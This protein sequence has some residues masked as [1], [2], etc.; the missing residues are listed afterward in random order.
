MFAVVAGV[1]ISSDEDCWAFPLE[2][3]VGFGASGVAEA[4]GSPKSAGV[5]T[6]GSVVSE[7]VDRCDGGDASVVEAGWMDWGA[8][9]AGA[10]K[11]MRSGGGGSRAYA[12]N[13]RASGGSAV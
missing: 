5:V 7:R 9:I 3:K 6:G 11:T 12:G 4:V 2:L 1:S 8:A 10:S 13:E